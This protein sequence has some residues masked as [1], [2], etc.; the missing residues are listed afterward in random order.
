MNDSRQNPAEA[1]CLISDRN[2]EL[3]TDFFHCHPVYQID[4]DGDEEQNTCA[5]KQTEQFCGGDACAVID[6]HDA[7]V[8]QIHGNH[9]DD[10]GEEKDSGALGAH[11]R[12]EKFRRTSQSSQIVENVSV[13]QGDGYSR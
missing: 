7:D 3:P 2:G 10:G 5:Q 12:C 8:E 11:F 6:I 13:V 1:G 4:E 9:A